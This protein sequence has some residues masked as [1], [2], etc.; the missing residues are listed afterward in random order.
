MD[1]KTASQNETPKSIRASDEVI[2]RF[3]TCA[4]ENGMTQGEALDAMISVYELS[5]GAKAYPA[6]EEEIS[7]FHRALNLML[8][9]YNTAIESAQTQRELARADVRRD[10]ESKDAIIQ[11]L[12]K[13]LLM[14]KDAVKRTAELE[15]QLAEAKEHLAAVMNEAASLRAL[16]QVL[17]DAKSAKAMEDTIVNLRKQVAVLESRSQEKDRVIEILSSFGSHLK[18]DAV[19]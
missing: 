1:Q 3:R 14:C 6:V 2:A 19:K 18:I 4:K 16:H 11:D 13:Q 8:S 15:N 10:L 17:P 5:V 7:S 9:L 12:Q